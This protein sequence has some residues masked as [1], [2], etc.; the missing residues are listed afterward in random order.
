MKVIGG[1]NERLVLKRTWTAEM[2]SLLCLTGF[3]L[4]MTSSTMGINLC[5]DSLIMSMGDSIHLSSFLGLAQWSPLVIGWFHLLSLVCP[6]PIIRFVLP[7]TL[8]QWSQLTVWA[9]ATRPAWIAVNPDL[10]TQ[11]RVAS[12]QIEQFLQNDLSYIQHP[13]PAYARMTIYTSDRLD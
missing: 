4:W 2:L 1:R 11:Y 6:N 5:D 8:P 12:A 10:T 9:L 13:C 7:Y 3:F